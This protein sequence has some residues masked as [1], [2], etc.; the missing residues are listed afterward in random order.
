METGYQRGQIQEESIYYE[1]PETHRSHA[2]RIGVNTFRDPHADGADMIE[3]ASCIDLAR[4]TTEEKESQ[5]S[6]LK[7]FQ[8]R[9]ADKAP[10]ALARCKRLLSPVTIFSPN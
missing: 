10:E 1:I 9:N 6:R 4:A 7:D 8:T 5:L 3:G 2:H